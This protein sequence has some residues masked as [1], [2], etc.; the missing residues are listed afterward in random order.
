MELNDPQFFQLFIDYLNEPVFV[1]DNE[2]RVIIANQA[3][4]DI[5]QM[6]PKD[7]IGYTLVE[8]VPPNEREHF[9]RVDRKV[10]DTGEDD[11]R[12]EE[13]TIEG[14]TN[15]ILTSKKRFISDSGDKYLICSILDVTELKETAQQLAE[16]KEQL[17]AALSEIKTL[18]E[19]LPICSYCRKIRDDEGLWQR[20]D[21]YVMKHT[22][23][24]FSHS[25]CKD[26]AKEHFPQYVKD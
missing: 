20:L 7:V 14:K 23:S 5:F 16:E 19:I 13:L 11:F 18:K 1:K 17:K 6:D 15:I 4:Y 2:H 25:I 26:C 8:A 21:E 3:F 22:D 24:S 12:E 10:L 9:L